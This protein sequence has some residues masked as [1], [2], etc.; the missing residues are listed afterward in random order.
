MVCL[1]D[2]IH[3]YLRLFKIKWNQS[4]SK[5]YSFYYFL[6][7]AAYSLPNYATELYNSS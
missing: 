7:L 4:T 6:Y 3:R 2:L 5:I 1:L